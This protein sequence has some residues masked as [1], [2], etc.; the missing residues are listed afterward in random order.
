MSDLASSFEDA[1]TRFQARA[2]LRL[3][4]DTL[5]WE[6]SRGRAQF[7]AFLVRIEDAAVRDHLSRIAARLAT[8]AGVEPYPDWYWHITV[9]GIGFQVIKRTQP[10]DVLRQDVPRIAS[11]AR[12]LLTRH[13]AFEAQVGLAN[14]FA[15]VVFVEVLDRGRCGAL[16]VAVREAADVPRLPVDDAP[17]LPHVSIA[18]FTSSEGLTQLKETLASLRAEGPGPAFT[19]GR[20]E[21]IKAW[22]SEETP[23]FDTLAT[24]PLRSAR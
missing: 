6:W 2:S 21:F 11:E 24:Y 8:V 13:E 15:E 23:E 22:L 12:A 7:L 1:W 17:F 10:D 4:G 16:N 14:A 20:L 9:K 5:E 18:R 19:V 3:V